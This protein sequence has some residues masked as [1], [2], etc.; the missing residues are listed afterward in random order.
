MIKQ[1]YTKDASKTTLGYESLLWLWVSSF[2]CGCPWWKPP[3]L[4]RALLPSLPPSTVLAVEHSCTAVFNCTKYIRWAWL[5]SAAWHARCRTW[6][7]GKPVENPFWT[8]E[9]WIKCQ[10]RKNHA[11]SYPANCVLK[12]NTLCGIAF[13]LSLFHPQTQHCHFTFTAAVA[14]E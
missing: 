3:L 4:F 9:S 5:A 8:R 1:K 2:K 11:R 14:V 10:L 6:V 7:T 12:N 13:D